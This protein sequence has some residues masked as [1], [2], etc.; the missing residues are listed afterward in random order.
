MT[1]T[2][3]MVSFGIHTE[4]YGGLH[5]SNSLCKYVHVLSE[6]D[7]FSANVHENDQF[8]NTLRILIFP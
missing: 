8:N 7:A 3:A 2:L 4:L 5:V 1:H 6:C